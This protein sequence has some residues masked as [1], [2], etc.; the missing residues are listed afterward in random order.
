[1]NTKRLGPKL[2]TPITLVILLGILAAGVGWGYKSFMATPPGPPPPTCVTMPMTE[3]TTGAVTVNVYNGG[4]STGLAGRIADA[5]RKGGFVVGTVANSSTKILTIS[6]VGNATDSP[7]VQL[8]A[9]WF[10]DPEIQADGRA[11]HSVDIVVGNGFMLDTGMAASPPSSIDIPAGEAC[12]PATGTP[13]P[14]PTDQATPGGQ[15]T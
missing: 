8:V 5:L 4:S 15:P 3:M 6:I 2:S 10:N 1:M 14:T 9:A 7:E 13:T 11:D 12:L